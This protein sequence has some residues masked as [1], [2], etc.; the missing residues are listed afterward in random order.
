MG[1][2]LFL[3]SYSFVPPKRG[4]ALEVA[5]FNF[6]CH[7]TGKLPVERLKSNQ[8][9]PLLW[10]NLERKELGGKRVFAFTDI[11]ETSAYWSTKILDRRRR[12]KGPY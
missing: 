7:A 11:D 4:A 1:P 9:S 8:T 3:S 5:F 10:R 6:H 12:Q 2:R